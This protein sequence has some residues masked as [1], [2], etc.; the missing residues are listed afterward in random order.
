MIILHLAHHPSGYYLWTERTPDSSPRSASKSPNKL[1]APVHP[2]E[3]GTKGLKEALRSIGSGI[4]ISKDTIETACAWLPSQG[5]LPLA[6]T[7][8]LGTPPGTRARPGIRPWSVAAR[9][10]T[11]PEIRDLLALCAD[12]RALA[13]GVVAGADL[14]WFV[15]AMRGSTAFAVRQCYLPEVREEDGAMR[16]RWGLSLDD[17]GRDQLLDLA[18]RMP[19]AC[20]CLT[21][22]GASSPP[23][24]P[25]RAVAGHF[26]AGALDSL[27]REANAPQ[28]VKAGRRRP[29]PDSVHDAWL[30]AL[31]SPDAA[32][33]WPDKDQLKELARQARQWSRPLGLSTHADYRMVFRLDE[34]GDGGAGSAGPTDGW[35]VTYLL[36]PKDDLSL[37]LPVADLWK[38][39]TRG[40]RWLQKRGGD[41]QEYL[42]AALAQAGGLCPEIGDS[43]ARKQPAGFPLDTAGAHRFLTTGAPALESAGFGV[44]LPSWWTGKG[45]RQRLSVRLQVKGPRMQGAAG[46]SAM[47][48]CEFDCELALGGERLSMEELQALA[49][50]KTPLVKLRGAW[51][52]LNAEQIRAAAEFWRSHPTGR[53][54]IRDIVRTALRGD[55]IAGLPVDGV[56]AAGPVGDLLKQLQGDTQFQEMA[57][58][59]CFAGVLR[60]YQQRGYSWLAFLRQWGLGA[61]LADDMGLGK[62]IQTLALLQRERERGET[63]P[64]LLVCP[65]SVVSNW[66]KEAERFTPGLTVLIHHGGD[67]RRRGAFREA[68]M[69]QAV[70]VSSF[71]LLQRDWELFRDVPWAGIVVDEAQN[72]KNPDTKQ[73]RA[74]RSLPADYRIALTGTPVENHVGDLWAI[75]E[76]LNPGL[77]GS[78]ADFKGRFLKPI[79]LRGD[80]E[81]AERLKQLTAPFILRRLKTD[82]AVISDLPEKMEMKTFCT[83]TR[84]QATLYAAV[85]REVDEALDR[86]EGIQR[87]GLI[88]VNPRQAEADLQ[89][90][91]ALSRRQLGH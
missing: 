85:L 41:A 32:I 5:G 55:E 69:E 53:S 7:P 67:R 68:A 47:T 21:E 25:T 79:Q 90:S 10:L 16:A 60:P 71:G 76:F 14:L 89:P 28:F 39:R 27:V 17:A 29:T 22:A 66:R 33:R 1:T 49:A 23:D 77:L 26:M 87:K 48:L 78:Q 3:G 62:T 50:L 18:G 13:R 73:S 52:E 19:G 38:P 11:F 43:L 46:L 80:R 59:G 37:L 51:V 35:Q 31:C 83:L 65:T 42:L 61:C 74:A 40:A 88:L 63:R 8:L 30:E 12:R 75:M 9:R 70:V 15:E 45:S 91:G 2:F 64:V 58:P 57:S 86:V 34:P 81:A 44:L 20:R 6:S 82:R 72:I 56:Q 54:T 36:Q 4:R 24:H 84:E